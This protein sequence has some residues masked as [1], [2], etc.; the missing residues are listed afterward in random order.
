MSGRKPNVKRESIG[1]RVENVAQEYRDPEIEYQ[2]V[3]YLVRAN[4]SACSAMSCAWLSDI[5]LQDVFAI[6]ADLRITMSHAMLMRELTE[7]GLCR[8][9]EK[10]LYDDAVKQLFDVDVSTVNVKNARHMMTQVLDLYDTRNILTGCG[11]VIGSMKNFKLEDA[12]RKL[13]VLGRRSSLHDPENQGMY[14]DDYEARVEEVKA[15]SDKADATEDGQ[16]GIPTG[17]YRLDRFIG[18]LM[19]KEFG[20]VAGVTGVG[21]TAALVSFGVHAWLNGY[22]VML[23][24][25]EMSKEALEFRLDSHL[26]R[27]PGMKFRVASLDDADYKQWDSTIKLYRATRDNLLYVAAYSRRFTVDNIE[28]DMLRIQ[29]ETGRRIAVVCADYLNIMDPVRKSGSGWE[30]QAEAVWDFKGLVHEY[31]LVGWTAGQV[32]DDAYD[33]EL[34]DSSD[35]KYARAISECAPVIAAIIRTDRDMIENRMKLQILKMRNAPVPTRPI[36]LHPNLDIMR[37]H[38]DVVGV[39]T[40]KGMSPDTVSEKR[41]TRRPNPNRKAQRGS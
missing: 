8:P 36:A 17:V 6:V 33:K 19:P 37:I 16:V 31:D 3:A 32:K 23:V 28:R 38:Q 13:A 26:T 15:T 27:I 10:G 21:K 14:L 2:L 30:D 22:D 7:R 4:P 5:L 40:L 41:Q 35:L 1:N 9:E 12:K 34:Y 29:E 11:E 24:S 39:K 20:V 25:G 18:G